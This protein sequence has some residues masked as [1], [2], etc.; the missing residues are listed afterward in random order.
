MAV[1]SLA[2]FRSF[3]AHAYLAC[4]IGAAAVVVVALIGRRVAGDRAGVV[5]GAI[6]AV[7][8]N[9]WLYDTTLMSESLYLLL[10]SA[11]VLTA[12]HVWAAPSL[13][14]ALVLGT[15]VGLA[16]LTRG[17]ALA[18]VPLLLVPAFVRPGVRQWKYAA[19]AVVVTGAVVAP[20]SVWNSVRF[21]Q[22][23]LVSVNSE[24]VLALANCPHT[25][26]ER[27]LGYWTPDCY[28]GNPTGN[29]AERGS[30]WQRRGI[31]YMGD[32]V[33]RLP[34]VVAARLGGTLGVFRPVKHVDYG[35]G[36]GRDRTWGLVGLAMYGVLVLAAVAG[37]VVLRRRRRPL[38]PLLAPVVMVLLVTASVYGSIRFRV[39]AE[40][41]IVVLAAVFID[42]VLRRDRERVA[43]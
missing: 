35:A 42:H 16:I 29:E 26:G 9:F 13:G 39:A 21:R 41:S 20:W 4:V 31:E 33:D 5:A 37:G 8:P 14:R 40:P 7:Y 22:P 36:E 1:E 25:Y 30:Y 15:L 24:E 27:D 11:V 19:V 32:H 17:E 10:I 18:L 28:I 23:V 38:W 34:V 12:L 3:S 6:A 43:A 2:G